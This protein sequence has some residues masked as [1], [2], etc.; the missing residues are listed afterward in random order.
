METESGSR[1]KYQTCQG[2]GGTLGCE[3]GTEAHAGL[4]DG[5]CLVLWRLCFQRETP[6]L[7]VKGMITSQEGMCVC[8]LNDLSRHP[9]HPETAAV[10]L[11]L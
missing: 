10:G 4:G 7:P 9:A 2:V 8:F 5:C 11:Y 6:D 1:A 3:L